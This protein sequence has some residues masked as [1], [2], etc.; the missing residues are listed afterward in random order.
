MLKMRELEARTGVG[1]EAIR[2][3]IKEGILPEPHKP[4][5][6]VANYDEEHVVR[7][8]L[9]RKLQEEKFLPLAEIKKILAQ[10]DFNTLS[11]SLSSFEANWLAMMGTDADALGSKTHQLNKVAEATGIDEKALRK[12]ARRGVIAITKEKGVDY[13]SHTDWLILERWSKLQ[14]LGYAS[15]A[16][17]DE[18][19]LGRYVDAVKKVAKAEVELFLAT[20]AGRDVLDSAELAARGV[21]GANDMLALFHTRE[22]RREIHERV[23]S[24]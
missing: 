2:F 7:I 3:Y 9:I 10:T 20:F 4:K 14:A 19:F 8:K 24:A 21:E 23:E 6:N 12:M 22:L 1:R 5:K 17:Y 18:E 13:I 15:E 16:G 11:D